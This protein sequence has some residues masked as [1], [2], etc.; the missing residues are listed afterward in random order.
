[1]VCIISSFGYDK[2]A[3]SLEVLAPCLKMSIIALSI[4]ALYF[5]CSLCKQ[6]SKVG[7]T[8]NENK[9]LQKNVEIGILVRGKKGHLRESFLYSARKKEEKLFYHFLW[10]QNVR[11]KLALSTRREQRQWILIRTQKKRILFFLLENRRKRT[12]KSFRLIYEFIAKKDKSY[13]F[14]FSLFLA[15]IFLLH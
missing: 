4:G 11:E 5:F 15:P 10:G 6:T 1:M 7:M 8:K 13:R 2:V 3:I 9:V 12:R 14:S